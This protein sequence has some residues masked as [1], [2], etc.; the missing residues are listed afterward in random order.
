MNTNTAF[1]EGYLLTADYG[2][3][4]LQLSAAFFTLQ[5]R[6]TDIFHNEYLYVN[7]RVL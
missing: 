4:T 7:K 2:I 5:T 1:S 6:I 3:E